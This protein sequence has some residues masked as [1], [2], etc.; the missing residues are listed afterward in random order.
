VQVLLLDRQ[1]LLDSATRE[2][3]RRVG[4]HAEVLR[5]DIA[6]WLA[7]PPASHWDIC[8]I[9]LFIHHFDTAQIAA[10]FD[11]LA[12]RTDMVIACEP[13]RGMLPLLASR[14]VGLLGA[15]AVTRKDAVLS[16]QAGFCGKELSALWP[17]TAWELDEGPA[18]LFSHVLIA[19]RR[20]G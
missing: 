10:L 14:L 16:V 8:V 4:W 11:V 15:G 12:T 5:M 19:T 18:R 7:Q 1:D 20:A 2:E 3:F 9:N 13:R 17:S 6:D